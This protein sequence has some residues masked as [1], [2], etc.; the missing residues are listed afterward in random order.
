[1][2]RKIKFGIIGCS[3]IAAR[4]TIPA[5]ISSKKAELHIIGSRS[6]EK[7]KEYAKKFN[8]SLFGNY[9]DVLNSRSDAVYISLPIGLHEKWVIMAAKSGKHIICE[10]SSTTSFRSAQRMVKACIH[11]NVRILEALMYRFHPQHTKVMDLVRKN[12]IG[13]LHAFYGRFCLPN[14]QNGDIRLRKEL[15]GGVLNDA[16][17]YPVNASRLI[18][19]QE[20]IEVA[21]NLL[22]DKKNKVDV[23]ADASLKYPNGK[24]AFVTA[25]YG[26]EYQ[27]N[28]ELL[29]D[30]GTI[31]VKRAYSV[32]KDY[33]A[34]LTVQSKS[35]LKIIRIKPVD[36]FLL[37]IN[38][39]CQ[40][41]KRK[42]S[43]SN[44]E[45]ELLNQAKVMDA[46]RIS[47][48]SKKTVHI[49]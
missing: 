29:G 35:G 41:I 12:Y 43:A 49:K 13:K 5:I 48:R 39:F 23:K 21:G 33:S 45:N 31:K 28:Y 9:Y 24:E 19:G 7:A 4:A 15:G 1:M 38:D 47:A 20:P 11:N 27:S 16:G 34:E 10:K 42:N 17:C 36:Q 32:P 22:F 44:F 14:P 26:M 30:S 18:F 8:C 6:K 3:R 46:I 25:G 40:E 37:M 2:Q